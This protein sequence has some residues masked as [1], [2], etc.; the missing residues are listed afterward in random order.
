[1]NLYEVILTDHKIIGVC[2]LMIIKS[3]AHPY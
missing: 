2:A 1:M 3:E